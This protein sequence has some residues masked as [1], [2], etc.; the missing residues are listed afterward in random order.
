MSGR[1]HPRLSERLARARVFPGDA[2]PRQ[3]GDHGLRRRRA[4]QAPRRASQGG[5]R[6][7]HLARCQG[8]H[9][10][11]QILERSAEE[12]HM[13]RRDIVVGLAASAASGVAAMS[14]GNAQ[15]KEPRAFMI[16]ASYY[17][18][19]RFLEAW[20][21]L[22]PKSETPLLLSAMGDWVFGRPD[23]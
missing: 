7:T 4:L 15:R 14:V 2:R 11:V 22:V 5:M 6:D 9:E 23:G 12:F 1:C 3:A 8:D 13:R 10:R 17:N 21:W 20:R 16:E 18:A 19:E